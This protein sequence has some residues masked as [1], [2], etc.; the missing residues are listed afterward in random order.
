MN[1]YGMKGTIFIGTEK[2]VPAK[3]TQ[4][5]GSTSPSVHEEQDE[6]LQIICTY[7][8]VHPGTVVIHSTDT[9]IAN[10]AVM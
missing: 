1:H 5:E 7:A 6:V 8:V 10:T 9:S 4:S 3:Q 2:V